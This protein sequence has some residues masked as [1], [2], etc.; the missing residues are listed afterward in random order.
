MS[1]EQALSLRTKMLGAL[2]REARLEAGKSIRE[3]AE[4]LGTSPSTISSYEH[5]RKG[6]SLPE[7][8]VLAYTFEVPLKLFWTG[9][10]GELS[11]A[12]TFNTART[13]AIRQRMIGVQLRQFRQKAEMTITRLAEVVDFPPGRVSAYERG[14]RAIPLPELE[15]LAATLGHQVEELV[16][17]EGPIGE[18]IEGHEAYEQFLQLPSELQHFVADPENLAYL[19]V[20]KQLSE[21][22]SERLMQISQALADL[23]PG[24]P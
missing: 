4:L 18:W 14:H 16:E 8:E 17:R 21:L 11:E 19:H 7:L 2:L 24:L 1:Q 22:S 13:I 9:E 3:T 12:P 15:V 23:V 20:A 5:G 6:I 10:L